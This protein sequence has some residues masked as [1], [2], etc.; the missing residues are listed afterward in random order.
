MQFSQKTVGPSRPRSIQSPPLLC[1]T[2]GLARPPTSSGLSYSPA[3]SPSTPSPAASPSTPDWHT[4][5]GS[6]E[7]LPLIA[8]ETKAQTDPEGPEEGTVVQPDHHE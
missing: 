5:S 1:F 7:S 3:A 6:I 4:R 8:G 2:L